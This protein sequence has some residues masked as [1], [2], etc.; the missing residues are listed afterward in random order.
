[1]L[2][3]HRGRAT[4]DEDKDEGDG[5]EEAAEEAEEGRPATRAPA[6][7]HRGIL[8][9]RGLVAVAT[10]RGSQL[11]AQAHPES[12]PDVVEILAAHSEVISQ[13]PRL[14]EAK[15]DNLH[16]PIMFCVQARRQLEEA[17][18]ACRAG[19]ARRREWLSFIFSAQF[20]HVCS[21]SLSKSET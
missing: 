1:M 17:P 13:H 2:A 21:E 11:K 4:E 18:Q 14:L 12:H 6:Q 3:T 5:E 19:G 7:D 20:R 15:L 8:R 9:K 10:R 16:I